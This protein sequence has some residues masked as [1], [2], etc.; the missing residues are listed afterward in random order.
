MSNGARGRF[1]KTAKLA[2]GAA[3]VVVSTA[4]VVVVLWPS[5]TSSPP[6]PILGQ[7]DGILAELPLGNVA[8]NTPRTLRVDR[9]A[10]I[11]VL[12]SGV[13]SIPALRK[14][15]KELGETEGAVIKVSD[16][17]EASLK[18][19]GFEIEPITPVRQLVG[20]EGVTEWRWQVDPE[21]PRANSSSTS[22]FRR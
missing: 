1:S 22:A 17:M 8:F 11:Q 12:L 14:Q 20:G 21:K 19:L 2:V 4:A 5:G 10:E 3:G 16:V 9:R 15:I 7:V 18:G 13:Q 6:D